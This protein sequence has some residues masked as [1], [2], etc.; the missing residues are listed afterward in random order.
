MCLSFKLVS[1]NASTAG[2]RVVKFPSMK[3]TLPMSYRKHGVRIES[4]FEETAL[5]DAE[6]SIKLSRYR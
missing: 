1:Q 2:G 6:A 4:C 3:T 5:K